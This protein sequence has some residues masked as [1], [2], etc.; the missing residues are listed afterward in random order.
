MVVC[1]SRERS[2]IRA[3]ESRREEDR[4]GTIVAPLN[5]R[6]TVMAMAYSTQTC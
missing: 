1:C 5:V 4:Y 6:H 2:S 3:A